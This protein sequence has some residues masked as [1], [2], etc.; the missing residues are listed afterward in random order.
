MKATDTTY[1]RRLEKPGQPVDVVIDTDAYNQVDDLYAIA[2]LLLSQDKL[3]LQAILAAPF[4]SPPSLGRLRQ[5]T[6]AKEGMEQSYQA[7]QD[8]LHI[9]G[10]DSFSSRVF[11]GSEASLPDEHTP[12]DSPAVQELI[13]LAREHSPERPL[14][15]I[16]IAVLTN[17]ASAILAA[18]DIVDR[19]VIIWLGGHSL[20]WGTCDDFNAF[21]DIAAARVVFGCRAAVIQ[22]PCNGVVS[23]FRISGIELQYWLEGKN[24]LCSYLLKQT[25]DLMGPKATFPGWSKPLWDV[26]AVAWLL[27]P[28]FTDDRYEHSP[29]FE[30]DLRYAQDHT[31][32]LIS[33]VYHIDRDRIYEDLFQ[34]LTSSN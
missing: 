24:P 26:V 6:S 5:N 27:N 14:Y 1:L 11:R 4:Y 17:V 7:I 29:I 9:M 23:E 15:I 2:Y 3:N 13:R 33:Y 20:D 22:L 21:Q 34:K 25:L 8:L 32:H 16:S 18:P 28:A 10:K 30:Y 19:I 12:V 31:R